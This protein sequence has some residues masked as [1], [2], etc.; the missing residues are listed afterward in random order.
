MLY[1]IQ[2]P[3]RWGELTCSNFV[4]VARWLRLQGR[5]LRFL[6]ERYPGSLS[7]LK[8]YRTH[9]NTSA[10]DTHITQRVR[11]YPKQYTIRCCI[12]TQNLCFCWQKIVLLESHL[13]LWGSLKSRAHDHSLHQQLPCIGHLHWLLHRGKYDI[14]FTVE[15]ALF[16]L[17]QSDGLD[18][19]GG[20]LQRTFSILQD[21]NMK[22]AT[23]LVTKDKRQNP[24]IRI[25]ILRN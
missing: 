10:Q 4:G 8:Q 17:L 23:P 3:S 15:Q 13:F 5:T 14:A 6:G 21:K 24:F 22:C 16:I 19:G 25:R 12:S 1:Q 20:P 9:E 2:S 18:A 7:I 11:A